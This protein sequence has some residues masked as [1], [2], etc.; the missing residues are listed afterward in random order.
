VTCPLRPPG[1]QQLLPPGRPAAGWILPLGGTEGP[2][3][4]SWQKKAL[5]DWVSE[6]AQVI[7]GE[8]NPPKDQGTHTKFPTAFQSSTDEAPADNRAA[9]LWPQQSSQRTHRRRRGGQADGQ[10]QRRGRRGQAPAPSFS[11]LAGHRAVLYLLPKAEPAAA[12]AGR[13]EGHRAG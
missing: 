11:P 13:Q 4:P 3:I 7:R 9:G 8:R 10:N 5:P 1:C 12:P 6:E 2:P